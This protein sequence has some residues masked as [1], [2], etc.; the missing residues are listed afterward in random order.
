MYWLFVYL[1]EQ[2]DLLHSKALFYKHY[3]QAGFVS[4]IVE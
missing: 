4:I 2:H 3:E 1:P